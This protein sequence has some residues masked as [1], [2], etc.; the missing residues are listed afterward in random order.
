VEAA[1]VVAGELEAVEESGGSLDVELPG[2]E[3]VDDDRESDLYGFAVFEWGELDV[4][5]GDEVAAGGFGGAEGGVALVEAVVEVAPE[6]SGEGGGFA[7]QAV[8]FDVAA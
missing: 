3:G 2:G 1:G 6:A 5:A 7:L 8:G 4:L